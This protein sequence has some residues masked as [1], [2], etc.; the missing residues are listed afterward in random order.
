MLIGHQNLVRI[1]KNLTD[2]DKLFHAY[3]FF[4]DS[5]IGKF[6]FAK[7]LANYFEKNFFEKP[8]GIL[9]EL[10]VISP[11]EKSLIGIDEIRNL[12]KFLCRKP[13]FSKKRTA[14]INDSENMTPEAQNAVL[15]IIEDYPESALIIFISKA[16]DL[17][18]PPLLSRLQKIY[19][20]RLSKAE[21]EKFLLSAFKN[22]ISVK[23]AE[24][25]SAMSFGRI[26]RAVELA[27]NK[28]QYKNDCENIE[29]I[30]ENNKLDEFFEGLIIDFR[31]DLVKNFPKI[32][33]IT[34]RLVFIKSL[35]T[36]KKL[37]IKAALK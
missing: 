14:I 22:E 29:G 32:K 11:N 24:E 2:S 3:L 17:L 31:R 21:I 8:S 15:K 13:V 25:I 30:I 34:K 35:N 27:E 33:E 10:L 37:Q 4:G 16:E 5:D 19:F 23:K 18:L 36:N 7:S 6:L 9:E 1:F 20:S 12:H 28:I 26:G